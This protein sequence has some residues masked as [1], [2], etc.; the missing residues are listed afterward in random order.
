MNWK[1][2]TVSAYQDIVEIFEKNKLPKDELDIKL[3]SYLKDLPEDEIEN[4]SIEDFRNLIKE[5]AFC[6]TQPTTTPNNSVKTKAGELFLIEDLFGIT[7]GEYID[8]ESFF[9]N[10]FVKNLP[11]ICSILYRQ[12]T[13]QEPLLYK[14]SFEEYGDWIYIRAELFEDLPIDTV[15]G[16]IPKYIAFKKKF[17][18]SFDSLVVSDSDELEVEEIPVQESYSDKAERIKEEEESNNRNKFGWDYFIWELSRLNNCTFEQ[19]TKIPLLQAFGLHA[20][21]QT[22]KIVV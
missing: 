20:L 22:F 5:I 15:Y 14:D 7:V 12:K 19:A 17:E 8:L 9:S 13:N 4:Y 18:E 2:V 21:K 10:G 3:I 6:Y 11:I 1:T 16:V